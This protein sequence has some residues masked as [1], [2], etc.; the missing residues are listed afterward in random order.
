[1]PLRAV[2]Y[3][4][5]SS[6]KE[7]MN[8]R[9]QRTALILILG[10]ACTSKAGEPGGE[11]LYPAQVPDTTWLRTHQR[12]CFG[13]DAKNFDE[14]IRDRTNVICGGTNAAGIGFA[15]GPF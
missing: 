10:L 11:L 14:V 12:L 7:I 13:V 1:M 4:T 2:A 6:G 8:T 5:L 9:I 15:G 3:L